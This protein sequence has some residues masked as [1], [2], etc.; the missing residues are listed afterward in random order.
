M[1]YKKYPSYKD[2]GI[3]W[4]GEIPSEWKITRLGNVSSIS[5]SGIDKKIN[6]DEKEIKII[7]FTDIHK[8]KNFILNSSKEYMIVTTSLDKKNKHQVKKGDLIFTP[9]SETIND[10]GISALVNEEL[11]ETSFSYHV[12][13]CNFTIDINH[14]YKKYLTNNTYCLAQFSSK[15]RG[16]TRQTL[17]RDDF[18]TLYL[19][20]PPIREQQQIANF[21]DKATAKIDTLREKQTK[22]IGLLKEKRQAVISHAVT[23]G[24]NPNVPMKDSGVEWLGEIP[25]HWEVS[26]LKFYTNVKG[27]IGFRGYTKDDLVSKEEGALVIGASEMNNNAKLEIKKPQY[28]SWYKYYESPEIILNQGDLLFVQRGSTVGKV[29]HI[30]FD[31]EEATINPSLVV[32][33]RIKL[34]PFYLKYYLLSNLIKAI[35]KV[36]TSNTAIP[37]ISQEQI[38]NYTLSFPKKEDEQQQIVNYL[39]EKTSKIDTLIEKSNKSIE[40]L[41]EKRTALISAAVTGKIDVREEV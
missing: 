36:E 41:K 26:K 13:R 34:N 23:K 15:A 25:E 8:A 35:V 20:L 14:E 1:K 39:D 37:M 2:S 40:L 33:K 6:K 21:L 19:S 28:I 32:L 3:D 22:Q 12:L 17:S 11:L 29:A 5:A 4:L 27:R 7:N 30:D 38:G 10:I 31:I 9:S 24:I 18:R 16:T